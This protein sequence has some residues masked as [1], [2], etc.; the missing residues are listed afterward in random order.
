MN[1]FFFESF[2]LFFTNNNHHLGIDYKRLKKILF[3]LFL[4]DH[5]PSKGIS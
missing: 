1:P 4:A 2:K 5:P 3:M